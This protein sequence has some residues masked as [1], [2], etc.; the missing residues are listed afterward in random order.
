M[1]SCQNY[2]PV[3]GPYYNTAPTKLGYPKRDPNF[4][5]Y[6]GEKCCFAV[7][8]PGQ[9]FGLRVHTRIEANPESPIPLI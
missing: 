9:G 2:G 5:N 4:D 3:L 8:G 6:P 1:G 7:W